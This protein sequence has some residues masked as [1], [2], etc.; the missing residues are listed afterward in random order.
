MSPRILVIGGS[1]RPKRLSPAISQ[2][3]AKVAS[4]SITAEYEVIDLKDWP[5]PMDAEPGIP[6]Y[7]DYQFEE[8]KAWSRKVASADA[9]VF[10][11]PEYNGG[12]PAALKN[13]LD[14]LAKEWRGKPA[15]IVTY[16]GGASGARAGNQL[17]D[18]LS[19]L[20]LKSVSQRP[21]FAI[22]RS[23]LAAGNGAI[24]ADAELGAQAKPLEQ[25]L[26]KLKELLVNIE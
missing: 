6:A 21:K 14:Q 11:T 2:W 1:V 4:Q 23:I 12:Y 16:G 19:G 25:A 24:D 22:P 13:A 5:L 17:N 26:E 15:L 3:V 20:G 9:F 10:V 18:V 7:S 8:T